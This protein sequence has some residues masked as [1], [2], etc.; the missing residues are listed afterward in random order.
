MG[1]PRVE[2][3][4]ELI[5]ALY[6]NEEMSIREIHEITGLCYGTVRRRLLGAGVELRSQAS[7]EWAQKK[8]D[9]SEYEKTIA[10]YERGIP[11]DLIAKHLGLS[12][13]GVYARLRRAGVELRDF[14]E[15]SRA[16]FKTRTGKTSPIRRK[17][18]G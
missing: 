16:A 9:H 18:N 4:D 17:E 7:H 12:E 15:R 11:V 5:V 8:L 6:E 3:D 13:S 14:S 2:T 1:W 10:L